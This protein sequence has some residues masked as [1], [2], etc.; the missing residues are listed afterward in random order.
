MEI[1]NRKVQPAFKKIENIDI[2]KLEKNNLS[3]NIPVYIINAGTQDVVKIDMIFNAGTWC[4]EVPLQASITNSM[5]TEGT[6]KLSSKQITEKLDFYGAF[7]Q[8]NIDFDNNIVSLISLNKHLPHTITILED[9]IKNACFPEK[10]FE[11]LIKNKKQNYILEGNKTSI[12]ARRKFLLEIFGKEH[13][14]G[15][16]VDLT[17]FS[18]LKNNKTKSFYNKFYSSDNCKIIVSGK[19][20]NNLL[21]D[22]NNY[23]GQDDWQKQFEPVENSYNINPGKSQKHFVNKENAVQSAIR[24]GKKLF[25]KLHPD[26]LQMLVLNTILGGYFGSRLMANIR[27]DKGYTYGIGSIVHSLKNSGYF[28]IITE[29]GSDVKNK[30]I[31]EIYKE[32]EKLKTELVPDN[33]LELVK[34]YLMGDIMRTLDGP[35]SLS[36]SYM[37]L[38]NYDLDFSYFKKLTN[39]IKNITSIEIQRL[40]NDYLDINSMYEIVAG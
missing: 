17:D 19:I 22:I 13:P 37:S 26:Y 8:Q 18:D 35:F 29:V 5:I 2:V 33:E 25:N 24:I 27:E 21:S 14:Y 30:A 20:Q 40:A 3:N 38:L 36:E 16:R 39:T 28:S 12:L 34:N 31:D 6:K 11:I 7:I 9:I 10:E 23:F 4:Q 1:L 15:N 32:I